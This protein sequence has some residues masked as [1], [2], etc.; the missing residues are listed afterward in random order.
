M[1]KLGWLAESQTGLL[2]SI[3]DGQYTA[4]PEAEDFDL[5]EL[6]VE[7]MDRWEECGSDDDSEAETV[8]APTPHPVSC[9]LPSLSGR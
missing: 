8:E 3:S 1:E 5:Q 7:I 4:N 9:W 6:L 2:H